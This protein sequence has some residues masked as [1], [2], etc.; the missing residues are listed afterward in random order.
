MGGNLDTIRC[1]IGADLL[2]LDGGILLFEENHGLGMVDRQL[3]QLMRS[4]LLNG[5]RGV[6]VGQITGF[7][8]D[9]SNGWTVA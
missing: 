4:G 9:R 8:D 7:E 6:A 5:L 2:S 3:T 1:G